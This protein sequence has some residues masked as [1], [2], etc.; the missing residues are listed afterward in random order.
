M[1]ALDGVEHHA[2]ARWP[3]DQIAGLEPNVALDFS[4]PLP[5]PTG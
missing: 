5:R 1:V 2:I 3:V 4:P